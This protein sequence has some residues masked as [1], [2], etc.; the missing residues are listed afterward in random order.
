MA[1]IHI[2]DFYKDSAKIFCQIYASFPRKVSLFVEDI[3]GPDTL[4]EY[5][6]HSS[7]HQS[8]LAAMLWLAEADY[9]YYTDVIRQEAI[10]QVTLTH[11]GFMLLSS[12]I[13]CQSL[14]KN[15]TIHVAPQLSSQFT[16]DAP[17]G[18]FSP[19]IDLVRMATRGGSSSALEQIMQV[20]FAQPRK[21]N[22]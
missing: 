18:N 4:D 2:A 1:D 5:G 16:Q 9:L 10:D 12:P 15:Q 17:H 14:L 3:C 22:A 6:L 21:N 11:S 19:A 7:R 13:S 8:C 20:L